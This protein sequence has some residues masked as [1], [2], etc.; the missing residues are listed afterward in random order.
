MTDQPRKIEDL[1]LEQVGDTVRRF[2]LIALQALTSATPVDL[3]FARGGWTPSVGTFDSD[4]LT[5]SGNR[6]ADRAAGER[7]LAANQAKA[8]AIASTYRIDQGPYYL[9]NNVPYV[10]FLNGG[11]SSQAP[12]GFVEIA[13]Q[14]AIRALGSAA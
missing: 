3:G 9:T 11:S 4:P 8:A 1:I 2:N 5:P 10:P 7:N 14:D 13:L 6:E 12:A